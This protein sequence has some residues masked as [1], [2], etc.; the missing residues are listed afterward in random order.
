[1]KMVAETARIPSESSVPLPATSSVAPPASL[2]ALLNPSADTSNSLSRSEDEIKDDNETRKADSPSNPS[3]TPAGKP[4]SGQPKAKRK[5]I[6]PEQLKELLAMFEQTDTPSFEVR[7]SLSK[8]LNMTNREIQV[9]FQNRRAKV[10]RAKAENAHRFLHHPMGHQ[11]GGGHGTNSGGNCT[12]QFIP[13]NG[14]GKMRDNSFNHAHPY[15]QPQRLRFQ[16]TITSHNRPNYKQNVPPPIKVAPYNN[17]MQPSPMPSPAPG[18]SPISPSFGSMQSLLSPLNAI[19]NGSVSSKWVPSPTTDRFG[20]TM[21]PPSSANANG[22]YQPNP[23]PPSPGHPYVMGLKQ[24]HTSN[25]PA[26]PAYSQQVSAFPTQMSPLGPRTTHLENGSSSLKFQNI[27]ST[28]FSD[29]GA[30][31]PERAAKMTEPAHL[32]NSMDILASVA[33]EECA[34]VEENGQCSQSGPNNGKWRPWD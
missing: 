12:Y 3:R 16:N 6:T 13:V 29:N 17:S 23:I 34:K 22:P 20:H 25:S 21:T 19:A 27:N 4:Q 26:N 5:R 2:S 10:N 9:W 18:L 15:P 24:T 30:H 11:A 8:K 31:S 33:A 1:M 32:A 28:D 7:E 14:T